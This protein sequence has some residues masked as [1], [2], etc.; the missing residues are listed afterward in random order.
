MRIRTIRAL[1]IGYE[2]E[3]N[4][5]ASYIIIKEKEHGYDIEEVLVPFER[6]KM[7]ESIE[8]S[9]MPEKEKLEVFVQK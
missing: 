5:T 7:L 4:N 6:E 3:P 8:K 9:T 1:G 2:N